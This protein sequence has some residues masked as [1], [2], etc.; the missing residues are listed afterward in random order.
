[1]VADFGASDD[2]LFG[3]W[4]TDRL[5]DQLWTGTGRQQRLDGGPGRGD[6]LLLHSSLL[7]PGFDAAT[8]SVDLRSGILVYARA[9][10]TSS[11]AAPGLEGLDL[12]TDGTAWTVR[13]S[14]SADDVWAAGTS[15]TRFRGRAGDD[16]FT[17]SAGDDVFD[18][19]AG[20]DRART[21]GGGEDTCTGVELFDLVGGAQDCEHVTP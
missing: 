21:L 15:G 1:V 9:G 10:T 17:G 12:S 20:T 16:A 7:N 5:D 6:S 8:G 19:G 4:G 18:G 13:G 3:G 2:R 14:A 11:A